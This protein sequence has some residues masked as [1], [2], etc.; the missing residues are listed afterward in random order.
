MIYIGF[1]AVGSS[2]SVEMNRDELQ[3]FLRGP[4][5]QGKYKHISGKNQANT[6]NKAFNT[7]DFCFIL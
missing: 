7:C 4:C 5:C 6:Q 1:F 3:T 2:F